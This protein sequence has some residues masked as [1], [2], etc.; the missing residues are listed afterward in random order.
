MTERDPAVQ[1]DVS[2]DDPRFNVTPYNVN[3]PLIQE[4]DVRAWYHAKDVVFSSTRFGEAYATVSLEGLPAKTVSQLNAVTNTACLSLHYEVPREVLFQIWDEAW[5]QIKTTIHWGLS[6]AARDIGVV[7]ILPIHYW[8][9][10]PTSAFL[11]DMV[12]IT[13]A[14]FVVPILRFSE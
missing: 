2:W 5:E 13:A 10:Q 4:P 9:N 11:Q 8:V 6:D 3:H 14:A 12:R 1:S 7:S